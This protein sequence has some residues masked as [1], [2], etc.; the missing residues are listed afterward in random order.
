MSE[1]KI[2]T[3]SLEGMRVLVDRKRCE[4]HEYDFQANRWRSKKD[5]PWP[6][7][8]P[9]ADQCLTGWNNVDR[10]A[11]VNA[12]TKPDEPGPPRPVTTR[13][14]M[15][16]RGIYSWPRDGLSDLT[17]IRFYQEPIRRFL[18]EETMTFPSE[19]SVIVV[20]CTDKISREAWCPPSQRDDAWFHDIRML[21]LGVFFRVLLGR[22]IPEVLMRDSCHAA[23]KRIHMG[24]VS[25]KTRQTLAYTESLTA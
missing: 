11:A 13:F 9:L 6:R 25:E 22:S 3:A 18:A 23:G 15:V 21:A 2:I 8:R 7:P 12:L 19:I 4:L 10:F 5:A 14:G 16:W 1:Q 24:D 17:P 20:A